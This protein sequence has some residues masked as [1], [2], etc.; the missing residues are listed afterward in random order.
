MVV[1]F[2]IVSMF[3]FVAISSCRHLPGDTGQQSQ[4]RSGGDASSDVHA[5]IRQRLQS[6][7]ELN[8]LAAAV[9]I[10]H[11]TKIPGTNTSWWTE[12]AATHL[13]SCPHGNWFFL[14]WHRAYLVA[15]EKVAAQL[16]NDPTFALPYWDWSKDIKLPAA[17][18]DMQSPLYLPPPAGMF[19]IPAGICR[20]ITEIVIPSKTSSEVVDRILALTDFDAFGSGR[21]AD[22]RSDP[23]I[24]RPG[25][26]EGGPHG[27][28]HSFIGSTSCP[29]GGMDSA[30]DPIFWI[31]HANID[32][33][34]EQWVR[35]VGPIVSL[36]GPP[37]P[38]EF[39]WTSDYWLDHDLGEFPAMAA[40]G[41]KTIAHFKV[42]DVINLGDSSVGTDYFYDT[43]LSQPSTIAVQPAMQVAKTTLELFARKIDRHF[44]AGLGR[45]VLN[46]SVTQ[47]GNT[48]A[49]E[50]FLDAVRA[51]KTTGKLKS[52]RLIANGVRVTQQSSLLLI[53]SFGNSLPYLRASEVTPHSPFFLSFFDPFGFAGHNHRSPNGAVNEGTSG[54]VF[55][56]LPLLT[57]QVN[58]GFNLKGFDGE[59]VFAIYGDKL[60]EA[61]ALK[62][63]ENLAVK[64]EFGI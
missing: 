52:L 12:L 32:R 14:P 43:H 48:A 18:R 40:D 33:I 27:A 20:L 36:P 25:A 60:T 47:D 15:F 10:M 17:F 54:F 7:P 8:R 62:A 34:W 23:E 19:P 30:L 22:L 41:S 11:D 64:V 38:S 28:V 29:M 24:Y 51:H 13:N 44:E 45:I 1:R 3:V 16:L 56:L 6:G 9:K 37:P 42:R 57:A 26:F 58:S 61:I 55:D 31:H 46:L 39:A 2:V 21:A 5:R 49:A 35:L 4:V 53:G 63:T 50:A 59:L